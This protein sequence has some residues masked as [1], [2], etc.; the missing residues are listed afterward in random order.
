MDGASRSDKVGLARIPRHAWIAAPVCLAFACTGSIGPEGGGPAQSTPSSQSPGST[1]PPLAKGDASLGGGSLGPDGAATGS[2][3][4]DPLSTAIGRLTNA[5]YS[6]TVTDLT[7]EP[8]GAAVT[9]S[10]P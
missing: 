4:I 6:Q 8:P 3:Y 5:E 10:F 9:Y 1:L 7:G 2:D